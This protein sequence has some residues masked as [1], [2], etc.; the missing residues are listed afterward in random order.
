MR[1]CL[2]CATRF[3]SAGWQCPACAWEPRTS[4]GWPLFAP[5]LASQN[6]D[7]S[8]EFFALLFAAEP[9]HFWFRARNRLLIWAIRKYFPDA[10]SLLE[11]GCG[12]GYVLAGIHAALPEITCAGSEA[13]LEGLAFAALRVPDVILSQMS[14]LRI[15]FENEFDVVGAFDVLEHIE[16]DERALGQMFQATAPGGGVIITVPQHQFLWSAVDEYSRHKRRYSRR[17]LLAKLRRAGFRDVRA[18]SFVSLLLPAMLASR[19]IRNRQREFDELTE[20]R[21]GRTVNAAME[22]IMDVERG[23]I[24]S[25]ARLPLGGSLLAIARKPKS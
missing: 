20:V 11:I 2:S 22:R 25:G 19:M 8:A 6:D 5:D 7:Y 15:P 23:L 12:T 10:A 21:I 3:E 16:E 18:T 13:F 1:V 4:G 17:D 14:A 9:G 24:R